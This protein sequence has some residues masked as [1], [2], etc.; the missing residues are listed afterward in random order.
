MRIEQSSLLSL[1]LQIHSYIVCK[2]INKTFILIIYKIFFTFFSEVQV[3]FLSADLQQAAPIKSTQITYI[4]YVVRAK[5]EIYTRNV[6][7]FCFVHRFF[8]F[9]YKYIKR[10]ERVYARFRVMY[11]HVVE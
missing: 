6:T 8:F 9:V 3:S 1:L 5:Q 2:V 10:K 7:L 4:I 11:L